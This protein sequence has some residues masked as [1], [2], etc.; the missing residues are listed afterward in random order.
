MAMLNNQMVYNTI[1]I[2]DTIYL[3]I[4]ICIYIW[5]DII[6]IIDGII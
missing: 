3:Y 6:D 5:H 4:Y 2:F 1:Y